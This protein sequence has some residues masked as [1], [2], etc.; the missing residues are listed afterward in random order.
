[1]S[2]TYSIGCEDCKVHLWVGQKLSG[3]PR[4]RIYS[5]GVET[6]RQKEFLETHRGHS[7]FFDEKCEGIDSEEYVEVHA[8]EDD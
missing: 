8:D 2:R 3:V 5:G 1:M 4:V 6:D 7:L